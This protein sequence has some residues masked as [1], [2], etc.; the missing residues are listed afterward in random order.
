MSGSTVVLLKRFEER[1]NDW[2]RSDIELFEP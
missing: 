2:N 1:W